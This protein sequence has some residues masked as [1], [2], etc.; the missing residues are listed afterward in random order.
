MT[1]YYKAYLLN[2]YKKVY[3]MHNP[4]SYTPI[5]EEVYLKTFSTRKNILACGRLVSDK[6]FDKLIKA[7]SVIANEFPNWDVDIAGQDMQ[8]S[9]YSIVLKDLVKSYGLEERIRFIGFHS[10]MDNVMKQHSVFCLCS[11]HEGFPNVLSEAL[12]MGMA[13]VSFDIVTGPREIIIDGLDGI[14][15]ENQDVEALTEGLRELLSSE[16]LRK[17]L[18]LKA[19]ENINRFRPECIITSWEAMFQS[20]IRHSKM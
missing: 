19:I 4:L 3:V 20:I 2:N 5:S 10:D 18:G 17:K 14:I 1:Y 15:V 13:A 11:K 12:S 7:F 9:N 16:D 6:G 8:N